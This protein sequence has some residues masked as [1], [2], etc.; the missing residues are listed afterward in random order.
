MIKLHACYQNKNLP[1]KT[2][3]ATRKVKR[4]SEKTKNE[5]LREMLERCIL[6][7]LQFRYVLMDS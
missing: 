2:Y 7:Q 6:N 4:T 1:R 3:I 5:L